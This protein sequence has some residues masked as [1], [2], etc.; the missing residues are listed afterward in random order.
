MWTAQLCHVTGVHPCDTVSP[1]SLSMGEAELSSNGIG[2]K[3]LQLPHLVKLAARQRCWLTLVTSG[4]LFSRAAP[5][6]L[7][8]TRDRCCHYPILYME[9]GKNEKTKTKAQTPVLAQVPWQALTPRHCSYPPCYCLPDSRRSH[10]QN[11]KSSLS[12]CLRVDDNTQENQTEQ[13]QTN[14]LGPKLHSE[15]VLN[16]SWAVNSF[17]ME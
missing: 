4:R 7:T 9:N 16:I 10:T 17:V 15:M 12:C 11:D 1:L 6:N 5:C 3:A 2:V 14:C 13:S 8:S